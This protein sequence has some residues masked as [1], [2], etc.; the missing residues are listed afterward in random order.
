MGGSE[1][2]LG[3]DLLRACAVLMV[4]ASH[5]TCHF[6]DWFALAVPASA[7]VVGD[8]G[9]ELFFAL[10]GFLIGRILIGL[11]AQRPDWRDFAVFMLRRAMRTLPLYYLWLA[12]L[13]ILA[14]PAQDMAHTALR[15]LTLSQ[16]LLAPWPQD[17]Y[18]AV[19][20]SLAIEEWF[21]L[22]FGL[23]LI[24]MSRRIGGVKALGWC[25]SLWLLLPL[26]LRLAT[27][28]RGGMVFHRID[29]IAYGVVMAWLW[30]EGA[31]LF[32]HPWKLLAAGVAANLAVLGGL[33][34]LPQG[35]LVPLGS[36]IEVI[37]ACLCL[38]AALRLTQCAAW[39][40]RPVRWIAER[41]YALYLMHL[42]IVVEGV[43]HQ[44]QQ[45]GLLPAWACVIVAVGLPFPLAELSRRLLE[46]PMLRLRPSQRRMSPRSPAAIQGLVLAGQ[47]S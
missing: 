16:N 42:T 18:F 38:P 14:P 30:L 44:L 2:V 33:V 36:N 40:E 7:D 15:F 27:G 22:L 19:S 35:L 41:S 43:E 8:I 5:W 45:P 24:G 29:E 6:G 28:E 9:V 17:Y 13:L 47:Q 11:C 1:R 31:W 32:R 4:L 25:L 10:S 3:L 20:W 26:T 46:L 21:Y 23:A 39:V 34:L 12:L 37:G